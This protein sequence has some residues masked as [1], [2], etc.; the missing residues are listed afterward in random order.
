MDGEGKTLGVTGGTPVVGPLLGLI[1]VVEV[2]DCAGLGVEDREAELNFSIRETKRA[3]RRR[4]MARTQ[5][6]TM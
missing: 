1:V 4:R 2:G 6:T 5:W 3:R